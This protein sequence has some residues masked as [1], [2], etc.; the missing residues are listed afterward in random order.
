VAL[1]SLARPI[2][3]IDDPDEARV[4]AI[5][6]H[7]APQLD[8][9]REGQDLRAALD[10]TEQSLGATQ[11]KLA[12]ERTSL[13]SVARQLEEAGRPVGGFGA[14][15]IGTLIG[16]LLC[17]FLPFSFKTPLALLMVVAAA[18]LAFFWYR[19][20]ERAEAL[21]RQRASL[22]RTSADLDTETSSLKT[23]LGTI[24]GELGRRSEGFPSIELA[25]VRFPLKLADISG[26]LVLLDQ[27]GSVD[28]V[29]L[30]AIDASG[31]EEGVAGITEKVDGLLAVP[32]MLSPSTTSNAEDPLERLY[33]E[34]DELSNL[35]G[36]FSESLGL[37]RDVEL[38]LPIVSPGSVLARRITENA[39]Q[40]PSPASAIVMS[41]GADDASRIGVFVEEV[42]QSRAHGQ[43]IFAELAEAHARLSAGCGLYASARQE[44]VNA[45]HGSWLEVLGRAN[46]CDRR[47]YC[48][49][50]IMS[51]GYVED[52]LGCPIDQA[53]RLSPDDLVAQLRN[54]ESIRHRL[55][56]E[57]EL[58]THL[59]AALV[60]VQEFMARADQGDGSQTRSRPR[61]V[62]DQF[63][64]CLLAFQRT[65]QKAASGSTFPVLNFSHEALL[66]YDPESEEWS[67]DL[68]PYVYRTHDVLRY[69]SV[70][71]AYSD[72]MIPLW[73]HLWTEK[74]D[75]RKT[76]TFRTNG[77]LIRMSEKEAEK[78][79]DVANQFRDDLRSVRENLN[80]I[81]ADL[82]SKVTEI[83]GFKE[84]MD[85][86]GLLSERARA[87]LEQSGSA[88][89]TE[90][91]SILA[92]VERYETILAAQPQSQMEARGT[93]QDPI[94]LVRGFDALIVADE[95]P[96]LRLLPG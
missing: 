60:G 54:D 24:Q 58:E 35:V 44:S 78:L 69:G 87:M 8:S 29:V 40:A 22:E 7:L 75:F 59:R 33:G 41:Q 2:E 70:V 34:E 66:Y 53:Y 68:T 5:I 65:F 32:P 28:E 37:L 9:W 21:R 19:A 49:R 88:M 89:E 4:L 45:L 31:L 13:Q 43:R 39:G 67:S 46:W 26:R 12:T 23:R 92:D 91:E 76:E 6:D 56:V 77:E 86:L 55:D 63:R 94:E 14:G 52:L 27:S 57:P 71:K 50:T 90:E 72:L 84:G 1:Q 51:P 95:A 96:Q 47:F 81:S 85:E 30:R 36:D 20:R 25:D 16:G 93:V 62:E 61:Y 79:I 10:E 38:S 11:G 3:N 48:A 83:D 17:F 82:R 80:I 73:E 42:E 18:A 15:A 64:E 74:A